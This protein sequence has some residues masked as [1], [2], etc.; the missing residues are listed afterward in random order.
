VEVEAPPN[1]GGVLLDVV[2]RR[3]ALLG[4]HVEDPDIATP[5]ASTAAIRRPEVPAPSSVTGR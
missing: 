3:V 4:G 2:L 1:V 5:A